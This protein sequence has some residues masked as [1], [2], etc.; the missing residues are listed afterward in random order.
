[1]TPRGLSS[2][3]SLVAQWLTTAKMLILDP[4]TST[5][6]PPPLSYHEASLEMVCRGPLTWRPT[7]AKG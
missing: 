1:M 4:T 5:A 7:F 6:T 3:A 2:R